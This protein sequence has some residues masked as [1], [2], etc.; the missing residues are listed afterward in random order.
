MDEKILMSREITDIISVCHVTSVHPRYDVRILHKECVSLARHGFAVALLV[1]DT[2]P[3]EEF[4]NVEIISTQFK[5][6]NRFDRM[7]ISKKRI[8]NLMREID[9]DIYHFHDPELLPEAAWIK[10]RGK[11]VIF[12]FHEDVAQQILFK[13][14]IPK[15]FRVIISNLYAKYERNMARKFDA[16]ISVTPK[17]VE[18]LK[19][20]HKKTIM[21]TNFPI[22]T[23][24]FSVYRSEKIRALCFAGVIAEDWSHDVIIRAI[25]SI[26]DV[27]YILAGSGS[28]VYIDQ[29]KKLKG[30]EKV[31]F[32]G[33][34]PHNEVKEIYDEA[35]VGMALLGFRTQVGDEGTL[36]NTKLFEFMAAGLPVICSNNRIWSEIIQKHEC[37]ISLDPEDIGE[38]SNAITKLIESPSLALEMGANGRYAVKHEY[39]WK[40]QEK[41]LISLYNYIIKGTECEF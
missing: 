37:G 27:E 38:I 3:D 41:K 32:L 23:E 12:D 24:D 30:W 40:T 28:S 6:R 20:I 5:P 16:L 26:D 33:K 34:I 29:L 10:H 25:E 13:T 18:K 31:R 1:N 15:C 8:R 21:V 36:G 2:L 11:T 22:V 4:E 39:N 14:W 17:I 19:R 35:M 9:A 7:F